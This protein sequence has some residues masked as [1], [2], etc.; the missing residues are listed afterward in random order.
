MG[1]IEMATKVAEADQ[2]ASWRLTGIGLLRILFGVVW[3]IDA[4]FKWQP[5]FINGL[6]SYITGALSGQSPQVRAWI[7]FW[8]HVVGVDP[9]FFAYL[10]AFG[11]TALA[12]ALILGVFT[13]LSS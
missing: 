8:H 13:N 9:R 3:G 2:L 12:V 6:E 11:E 4:W 10:V 7:H 5:A 1:G